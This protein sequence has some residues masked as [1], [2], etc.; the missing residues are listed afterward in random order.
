[1][2]FGH[3]RTVRPAN[4][5]LPAGAARPFRR[6]RHPN[7]RKAAMRT[8]WASFGTWSGLL[9]LATLFPACAQTAP[10][11][12]GKTITMTIGFEAGNRVDLY[13]RILGRALTRYLPG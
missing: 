13:G 11:F 5:G 12:E 3:V 9:W 6:G 8:P 10:S 1:R 4:G 7:R 2:T